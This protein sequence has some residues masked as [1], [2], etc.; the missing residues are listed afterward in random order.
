[1][2]QLIARTPQE[3]VEAVLS[4]FNTFLNDH[5]AAEKKASGMAMSM[6]L[7]YRDKE[8]LVTEMVDLA[9]EEMMHFRECVRLLHDRGLHLQPDEKDEYVNRLR[10]Q[11]RG[12]PQHML[13]DRLLIGSIIEARGVERFGLVAEALPPGDMKDFYQAITASEER[14]NDLFFDLAEGYF[15]EEEVIA[16]LDELV[17]FEAGLL[18]SLPVRAALH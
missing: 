1:M 13:L 18:V 14:H 11:V 6:A 9:I 12:N 15:P 8:R 3:W 17:R 5:A 7:H 4:D 16:R 2:P 10:Q